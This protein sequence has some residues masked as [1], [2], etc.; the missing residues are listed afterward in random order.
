MSKTLKST[1]YLG[2][3]I[4]AFGC[5]NGSSGGNAPANAPA[6]A[7]PTNNGTANLAVES[8][9]NNGQVTVPIKLTSTNNP[10]GVQFDLRFDSSKLTFD[11]LTAG[12]AATAAVKTVTQRVQPN[13]D[14]RVLI[15]G[16]NQNTIADGTVAEAVFTTT[17]NSGDTAAVELIDVKASDPAAKEVASSKTDGTVTIQ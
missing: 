3:L 16:M 5:S 6:P 7:A 15:I 2:V 8:V 10:A 4:V 9:T 13:G 17:G 11:R 14:I 1:L 12:P